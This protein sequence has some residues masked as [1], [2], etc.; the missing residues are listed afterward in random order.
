MCE[1]D[2]RARLCTQSELLWNNGTNNPCTYNKQQVWTDSWCQGED[3]AAPEY[4]MVMD[5]A[6]PLG[7]TKRK[8]RC[9]P[10]DGRVRAMVVCC[11]DTKTYP[12]AENNATLAEVQA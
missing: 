9:V 12:I 6:G 3:A 5:A 8:A 1:I 7:D 2:M 4:T 11:A 10:K